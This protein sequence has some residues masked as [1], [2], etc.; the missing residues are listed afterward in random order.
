MIA[1]YFLKIPEE[2]FLSKNITPQGETNVF[3]P[4]FLTLK[5]FATSM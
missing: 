1:G 3:I 4:Q 5:E 2:I